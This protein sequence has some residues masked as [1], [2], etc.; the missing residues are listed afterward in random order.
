MNDEA[1][2]QLSTVEMELAN[3]TEWIFTKQLIIEKVY[4]LFGQLYLIL[5]YP[6][7]LSTENIFAVRTLFWWGNIFSVSL[8]LSSKRFND[9]KNIYKQFNF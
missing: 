7:M 2:I 4:R 9:C 1:K 6:G 3:N 5:D 8:H